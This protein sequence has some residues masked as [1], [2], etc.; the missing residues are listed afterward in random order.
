MRI[1]CI[2]C[3]HGR[4]L[5]LTLPSGDTLIHTG[6]YSRRGDESDVRSFLKWLEA[7]P[8]KHRVFVDGNH[9]GFSEEYPESMRY[10]VAE[11]APSVHYLNDSG[12]ILDGLRF[13]GS[14]VTP[15]FLDWWWNRQ[16]GPKIQKHWDKIPDDIQVLVTH[17]PALGHLDLIMP[18]FAS[19]RDEHQGCGNL[20]TTIDGRLKQL[21]LHT[22]SHLHYEGCTNKTEKGVIYVNAA[23]VDDGYTLRPMGQIQVV[24]ISP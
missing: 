22:F 3:S 6:D 15:Y 18:G 10:M 7:Q 23:V 13:W 5:N 19:D 21:K 4:H 8:F 24:E 2:G 12:V 20:R 16:R 17:G 11:I 14:P 9:D 1:V